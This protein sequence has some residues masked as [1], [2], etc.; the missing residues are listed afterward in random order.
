MLHTKGIF[1]EQ[2]PISVG[3]RIEHPV[4]IINLMRYGD[5]YKDYS[6]IGAATYSLNYT[7]RKIKR[8]VYTFCMC[9]GG[10]VMNPSSEENLPQNMLFVI[11]V[12]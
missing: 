10:E 6:A 11:L 12:R 3:V 4:E 1:L 8:G 5:K 7:D 9:P 2:K